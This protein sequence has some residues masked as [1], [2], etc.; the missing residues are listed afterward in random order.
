MLLD[1]TLKEATHSFEVIP[2]MDEENERI[3]FFIQLIGGSFIIAEKI[4]PGGKWSQIE[5]DAYAAELQHAIYHS[6]DNANVNTLMDDAMP[7]SE[8]YY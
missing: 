6:I 1:I 4:N 8:F 5:G 7:L 2:L 3:L